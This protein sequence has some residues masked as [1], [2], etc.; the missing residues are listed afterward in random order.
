MTRE[1]KKPRG[2]LCDGKIQPDIDDDREE[3]DV[4]SSHHQQGLLQHEHLVER[5]VHLGGEPG[6]WALTGLH[7]F[8]NLEAKRASA[9]QEASGLP[10]LTP[11]GC[12]VQTIP[13][14]GGKDGQVLAPSTHSLGR[15]A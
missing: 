15:E 2:Y 3:Q 6:K 1:R 7:G 12:C 10:H 5:V 13:T 14:Q 4:E 9:G 8:R 11:R